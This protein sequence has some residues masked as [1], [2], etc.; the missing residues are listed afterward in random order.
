L[1]RLPDADVKE[2]LRRCRAFIFPGEED[3]GLAPLEAMASGR[4]V[5]ALA[6]GGALETVVEGVTGAF[7]REPTVAALAGVLHTFDAAHYDPVAL[8]R[9]AETFDRAVFAQRLREFVKQSTGLSV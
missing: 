1:G 4:P 2:H 8:R 5:V 6:A 7:F 9:H 3:F